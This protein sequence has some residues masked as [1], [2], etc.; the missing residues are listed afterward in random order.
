MVSLFYNIASEVKNEYFIVHE[1]DFT[2]VKTDF[3]FVKTDFTLIK[4]DFISHESALLLK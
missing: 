3:T 1:T 4:S 2:V